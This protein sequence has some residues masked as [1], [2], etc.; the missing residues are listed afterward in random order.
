MDGKAK[1][2]EH[3]ASV[4]PRQSQRRRKLKRHRALQIERLESRCLLTA[5]LFALPR[6]DTGVIVELNPDNGA[7][8]R[9]F[10]APVPAGSATNGL[11]YDGQSLFY[12]SYNSNTLYQLDPDTG[13]V[14]DA[15]TFPEL[16]A[17]L[18]DGLAALN[19]L[20]YLQAAGT[21]QILIVD[22]RSD[23]IVGSHILGGLNLVGGFTAVDDPDELIALA[24][25]NTAVRIAP[26]TG[27]VLGTFSLGGF[28]ALGAAYVNGSLYFGGGGSNQIR[29]TNR[30]GG[31]LTTLTLPYTVSALAGDPHSDASWAVDW[32]VSIDDAT[33][34]LYVFD[35][36]TDTVW[37]TVNLPMS[38]WND[39]REVVIAADQSLAFVSDMQT[40]GVWVVDLMT[41]SLAAGVN[42]IP[43]SG[44]PQD[45]EITPDG[46]F[47]L[48]ADGSGGGPLSVVEIAARAEVGTYTGGNQR[49]AVAAAEGGNVLVA[50]AQAGVVRRLLL[51]PT[52]AVS[53]L[54]QTL[55]VPNVSNVV[56]APDGRTGVALNGPA[57]AIQSFRLYG[58][59]AVDLRQLPALPAE[60]PQAIG[61]VFSP[62]GNRFYARSDTGT[63]SVWGYDPATAQLSGSPL[64]IFSVGMADAAAGVDSLDITRDGAKLYISE[65]SVVTVYDAATGDPLP[66]PSAPPGERNYAG[67][68]LPAVPAAPPGPRGVYVDDATSSVQVFDLSSDRLIGSLP[69]PLPGGEATWEVALSPD[70][71]LAF[72]AH[73][74]A[75]LV[76]V[77][78]VAAV[79]LAAG[80]NPIA[81]TAYPGDLEV[82]PDGRYLLAAT[83]LGFGGPLSVVDV[84]L[85]SEISLSYVGASR[86]AVT[87]SQSGSVLVAD[88]G[89]RTVRRMVLDSNGMLIDTGESLYEPVSSYVRNVVLAP[90]GRTGV[91]VNSSE[92]SLRSFMVS[93]MRG[94]D[95][96]VLPGGGTA[97]GGV[98][99]PG[100]DRFFAR[101]SDG[102]LTAWAYDPATAAF[103]ESPLYTQAVGT[104]PA[105]VGSDQL[106]VS[107]DGN[108][109]YVTASTQVKV[110]DAATG[111]LLSSLADAAHT[112]V[113]IAL[114]GAQSPPAVPQG[115][116]LD[117]QNATL[118][119][120]NAD[121]RHPLGAVY[122][123]PSPYGTDLRDV[124]MTPDQ[125]WAFVA[126][127]M[128]RRVW[129]VDLSTRR[130]A[131]GVNPI[132][133]NAVPVDL[134][135]SANGRFLL[136]GSDPGYGIPAILAVDVATRAVRGTYTPEN[137]AQS[138][139]A[140]T[141]DGTVLSADY[142]AG[143]VRGVSLSVGGGLIDTGKT[144]AFPAV[145]NV[146]PA[147]DGRTAVA[148]G[149]GWLRS[150]VVREMAVVE[151]RN[152]G[153]LPQPE[154]PPLGGVFSPD[155]HRLYVR[156]AGTVSAWGYYPAT[157][158]L[159]GKP[160]YSINAGT[161][162]NLFG[163]DQIDI[164]AD[165]SRLYVVADGAVKVYDAVSGGFV[166]S[167][168]QGSQQHTGVSVAPALTAATVPVVRGVYLDRMTSTL[169]VLDVSRDQLL[170]TVT[171][172]PAGATATHEA[173]ISPDQRLAFVSDY[174][175]QAIWVVDLETM[176]LAAGTN[177]IPV[178]TSPEDMDITPDGRFLLVS[179][180]TAS[181][182]CVVDIAARQ[183]VS[184]L[185]TTSAESVAVGRDG[186]V[187]IGRAGTRRLLLTDD[188]VLVD[189]GQYLSGVG[190]NVVVAPDGR[191]GVQLGSTTVRSFW[192]D[193]MT[194]LDSRSLGSVMG[195]V[196]SPRGDRLFV[197]TLGSLSAWTYNPSTGKLGENPLYVVL[198]GTSDWWSGV[199]Q[200]DISPDGS[201][202]YVSDNAAL[203]IYDAA[204]GGLLRF[205]GQGGHDY[206]GVDLPAAELPSRVAPM[207]GVVI[208]D[209]TSTLHVIDAATDTVLGSL[210]L[211]IS[212]G[213]STWDVAITPDQALAFVADHQAKLVWGVDLNTISLLGSIV[214][215]PSP[216]DLE[217]TPDGRFL[218]VAD[219]VSAP[220]GVV[221]IA[222]WAQVSTGRNATSVTAAADGT[223][224][225][226][227]Y[228]GNRVDRL[229]LSEEGSLTATGESLA[230][231]QPL[232]VVLAPD[233]R[234]GVALTYGASGLQSFV[235]AGMAAVDLRAPVDQTDSSS[236]PVSAVFSPGGDRLYVRSSGGMVSAWAYDLAT[237]QLGSLPLY[238]VRAGSASVFLGIDQLDLSPDG[239]KLYVTDNTAVKVYDAA[240]GILLHTWGD[241]QHDY[242]GLDFAT[243][244]AG[245][246][247]R[248][249]AVDLE[250]AAVHIFNP[251]NNALLGIVPM[252]SPSWESARDVAISP[253]QRQAF[254]T[255]AAGRQVWVVDLD[256]LRLADRDNPLPVNLAPQDV[257][258]TP[259]GR[260]LLVAGQTQQSDEPL[261]SVI[262]LAT[263][264]VAGTYTGGPSFSSVAAGP[265]GAVLLADWQAGLVR[266]LTLLPSGA[267]TDPD[268][269]LMLAGA[270]NVVLAPDGR[271]GVALDL[272]GAGRLQS[273]MV[274]G[275]AAVDVRAASGGT[276]AVGGVFS[277][278]GYR[279]YAQTSDGRVSAWPY[280]PAT[281]Q[282][283]SAPLYEIS[284]NAGSSAVGTD[285]ID[286]SEDGNWL[287]VSDGTRIRSYDAATGVA[288]GIYG[289]PGRFA[290]L[291][292]GHVPAAPPVLPEVRGAYLDDNT[293]TLH[294][295]DV[296]TDTLV[297]TVPLPIP[298]GNRA[299]DVAI[300]PDQTL[301]F[302][303]DYESRLV[304]AVDLQG[305][306]IATGIN[307]I[308]VGI[309]IAD[310][311]VTPDGRHLLVSGSGYTKI[312]DVATRSPGT[313]LNVGGAAVA[314]GAGGDVLVA[315]SGQVRRLTIADGAL[316]NTGQ[317]LAAMSLFNVVAA[318]GGR[319][320]VALRYGAS[321][322]VQ[323]F[324][325]SPAGLAAVD[326]R[327]LAN[328]MSAVFSP[329]GD[330][331]YVRTSS[332]LSAWA[333]DPATGQLGNSPWFAV[334][335]VPAGPLAGVDQLDISPD[336]SRLYATSNTVVMVHD[337]RTGRM[338][339]AFANPAHRYYGLDV[340]SVAT[341][342][343][344]IAASPPHRGA[345]IDDATSMLHVIDVNTGSVL[346]RVVLP[347]GNYTLD[348]AITPD[349][350]W[351]F[352]SETALNRLW[353]VDLAT[354]SLADGVNPVPLTTSAFDLEVSP[355]SRF[356]LVSDGSSSTAPLN[357]VDV[358]TRAVVGSY[359]GGIY[360]NAVA[361]S[362]S[363][364][365]A[366]ADSGAGQVRRLTLSRGG[367]LTDTG[368][369]L[370]LA[371]AVNVVFA[372]DG[373]NGVAL[374]PSGGLQSFLVAG[375][376]PVANR[377]LSNAICGVFRPQGDRFYARTSNGSLTAWSYDAATGQLGELPLFQISLGNA[378]AP[379][380]VDQL[381]ISPDGGVLYVTDGSAI[382]TYDAL[383]GEFLG[384]QGRPGQAYVGLDIAADVPAAPATAAATMRGVYVD[385]LTG[386]VHVLDAATDTLLA[387]LPLPSGYANGRWD[388]A[389]APDQSRAF[390]ADQALGGIWVVDLVGLTLE[391]IPLPLQLPLHN[392][393]LTD[394][395]VTADGRFLLA[396]GGSKLSVVEIA[397]KSVTD[398][399]DLGTIS[400][401][402]IGS[403]GSVLVSLPGAG[404]VRR[405]VLDVGGRL[406]DLEQTLTVPAAHNVVVAPDGRTA[407]VFD[408]NS[409]TLSSFFVFGM[410]GIDTRQLS[411]T[412]PAVGGAFSPHG[413]R[414]FV[415]TGAGTVTAWS[416]DPATGRLGP[417]PLYTI[418]VGAAS[419]YP[420][421]DQLDVSPDGA[422]LY[423][424]D[425]TAVK[426]YDTA[427]GA[428]LHSLAN[429]AHRYV[430]IDLSRPVATAAPRVAVVDDERSELYLLD[431]S[432]LEILSR[433]PLGSLTGNRYTLDVVVSPDRSLA[434]VSE[435]NLSAVWVVDL[436][437]AELAAGTNPIPVST[438]P[439]DLELTPDGRFLLV[440][441]GPSAPLSVVDVAAR[442]QI[443]TYLP[444]TS[445]DAVAAGSGG[446][447]LVA[448]A[449]GGFVRRWAIDTAG[450]MSDTGHVLAHSGAVNVVLAPNGV[451]GVALS[452]GIIQSF[453]VPGMSPVAS[454]NAGNAISG[455]FSPRGDRFYVRTVDGLLSAWSHDPGTG[456]LGQFPLY[457]LSVGMTAAI[458]GVD[459]VDVSPDGTRLFVSGGS[460]V[461][462]Y[463]TATGAFIARIAGSGVNFLG[464]DVFPE[465]A[466]PPAVAPPLGMYID[467]NTSLL[468][469]FDVSQDVLLGKVPIPNNSG[470]G[471]WDVAMTPDGSLA[472]VSDYEGQS[473]WVV[474]LQTISLATWGNPISLATAAQDLDVTPDGRY[475]LVSG[476][477]GSS[478]ISVVDIAAR[479][480]VGSS[481]SGSWNAVA[482]GYDG[483]LL[484][485]DNALGHVRRLLIANGGPA[486]DTGQSLAV[487]AVSNVILAPDGRT[488][489]GLGL[490]SH[491]LQSFQAGSMTAVDTRTQ[492]WPISAVFSPS[493]DRLYVRSGNGSIGVWAYDPATGQLGSDP[494]FS[495]GVAS[496]PAYSGV[497]QLAISPDGTKLYVTESPSVRVYDATNGALLTS[498]SDIEHRYVGIVAGAGLAPPTA[499]RQRGV[500]IDDQTGTLHVFDPEAGVWLGSVP[501]PG[502]SGNRTWDAAVSPDQTVAFVTDSEG[503]R[504]WVVDL[505]TLRLAEGL[506][507]LALGL[508]PEDLD[509]TRDGRFLL[510]GGQPWQ[511]GG[512]NLA[513]VD[514]LTR[515]P[516][517]MIEI[518]SNM[519]TV[520]AGR[521][522]QVLIAEPEIGRVR[523]LSLSAEGVLADT[524][525][526]LAMPGPAN[527]IV[528]PDGRTG[529]AVSPSAGV[530]QSFVVSGL[531]AVATRSLPEVLSGAF[532]PSGYRFY[533]RT[534]GSISGWGYDP[535]TGQLS[536][537]PLFSVS[538]GGVPWTAGADRIDVSPDGNLLYA[539]SAGEVRIY[540]ATTGAEV[541]SPLVSDGDFVGLDIAP[542]AVATQRPVSLGAYV[543]ANSSLLYVFDAQTDRVLGKLLLPSHSGT[544]R[545]VVIAPD[546]TRAFVLDNGPKLVWTVDLTTISLA[547]GG[548]P[549]S[550]SE[551]PQDA[552]VTADGRWLLIGNA[553]GSVSVVNTA[554]SSLAGPNFS[555]GGQAVAVGS[556]EDLVV[557]NYTAG[558]VRRLAVSRGGAIRDTGQK[559]LLPT[560]G[561]VTLAP[562]GRTGVAIDRSGRVAQPFLLSGMQSVA[563]RVLPG[564]G[565]AMGGVFNP[566]G[567]RFYVRTSDGTLSAWTYDP[568][569]AELGAEPL[570]VRWAGT[571]SAHVGIDQMALSPDGSR[572]LVTD[573]SVVR[574]YDPDTGELLGAWGRY[575]D[576]YVGIDIPAAQPA[577]PEPPLPNRGAYIDNNT[578]TLQVLDLATDT[579]LGSVVL[580][581]AG[582]NQ[583]WD[584]VMAPGQGL[585][586]V[587]DLES[588]RIWVVDLDSLAL[589]PG[590]NPIL[591]SIEPA[592]MDVTPD[593]RFLLAGGVT[594]TPITV[595]DLATRAE[596]GDGPSAYSGAAVAAGPHGTVLVAQ[597]ESGSGRVSRYAVGADG[598]LHDTGQGLELASV[599]NVVLAPDGRT[600]VAIA[601]G[602]D[603]F[604]SFSVVGMK[605][606]A[607]R[608][609]PAGSAPS[610]AVF[611]PRGDRLFVRTAA[612]TVTAWSYD[613]ATGQVGSAPLYTIATGMAGYQTGADDL[614]VSPDGTRLYVTGQQA[615]NVYEAATGG[616]LTTLAD[617]S[618]AYVGIV[619]PPLSAAR[620]PVWG[621]YVEANASSLQIVDTNTDTWFG[622]VAL[623]APNTTLRD[624]VIAPDQSLAF[625]SEPANSRVWVVDL[626]TLSLAAGRNPIPLGIPAQDL[627][628][629]PDG[630]YL[631]AGNGGGSAPLVVVDMAA[632]IVVSRY[633]DAGYR[634]AV[635]T[636][637]AGDVLVADGTGTA[638]RRLTLGYGGV[639][640]GTGESLALPNVDNLVAA[641]DGRT[642][643]ALQDTG[644][645][646]SFV[647]AGMTAVDTRSRG[648]LVGGIFSPGGDRL[649]LR[650]SDGTVSAWGYDPAT[651]QVDETPLF[652]VAAGGAA[653]YAGVDGI[654]ISPDGTRLYVTASSTT[655][656]L[657][658]AQGALLAFFTDP[659]HRYVGL[660]IATPPPPAAPGKIRGAV[661]EDRNGNGI[662]DAGEPGVPGWQIYLDRYQRGVANIGGSL[663]PDDYAVGTTL[664]QIPL[665]ATLSA[666]GA[667]V[668]DPTVTAQRDLAAATGTMV[669]ANGDQRL[670]SAGSRAL[671]VDFAQNVRSIRIDFSSQSALAQGQLLVYDAAGNLVDGYTT[672]ML[673]S[674]Q[675]ETMAV[676]SPSTAIA[677]AV[678]SGLS[679][680]PGLLD[681]L[682]VGPAERSALTD[683]D[684][685]Y[686]FH[687]VEAGSYV[688]AEVPRTGWVPTAPSPAEAAEVLSW[689]DEAAFLAAHPAAVL[690]TFDGFSQGQLLGGPS[691]RVGGVNY[692]SNSSLV[693]WS[694]GPSG[695]GTAVSGPNKLIQ[696]LV[697]PPPGIAL[698][699]WILTFGEG[700]LVE[701]IGFHVL[702]A[703]LNA[704]YQILVEDAA[705]AVQ[706][707]E[708][709][710]PDDPTYRGF[711]SAAGIRQITIRHDPAASGA[712]AFALDNVA[713]TPLQ[714]LLPGMHLVDL[715]P[716]QT[717]AGLDFGNRSDVPGPPDL[718]DSVPNQAGRK[719]Q[720]VSLPE[721]TFTDPGLTFDEYTATVNWGDG[722][723]DQPAVITKPTLNAPGAVSGTHI[724]EQ[725]GVYT[726][727]VTVRD[728]DLGED[729]ISFTM[730]IGAGELVDRWIFYN[731]SAYD[732][733]D[734]AANTGDFS[735]IAPHTPVVGG[736]GPHPT[737]RDEPG[738]E[739]GKEALL[740]GQTATYANYTSY[741]RGINGIMVDLVGLF[742]TPTTADFEFRVGNHD[743][744]AS[745]AVAPTPASITVFPGAG[746]PNGSGAPSDRV[747]IIW[748]D[749][750][751]QNTWLQ[752][753]VLA[754]AVTGLDSPDVFYFGNAI[755]D[756]G[757]ANTSTFAF[758][759]VTDELA[760]RG[761]PH[762]F[763]NPAPITDPH[764]F[765]KDSFVTVSDELVARNHGTNFLNALRLITVPALPAGGMPLGAAA[766]AEFE[767]SQSGL[768]G[769]SADGALLA[770]ADPHSLLAMPVAGRFDAQLVAR[771]FPHAAS[772]SPSPRPRADRLRDAAW[773]TDRDRVFDVVGRH[774]PVR[775]WQTVESTP[776]LDEVLSLLAD[777]AQAETAPSLDAVFAGW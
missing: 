28:S 680:Y 447:V 650:S 546:Q 174:D 110:Y 372:P 296:Q 514:L 628:I 218:L 727:T 704:Q 270:A 290:G 160:L 770:M 302:V 479:R 312:I 294:V 475:L 762:N 121:T 359:G 642:G 543:A 167:F 635:T 508:I 60:F 205:L 438:S 724:Y 96:R 548:T 320:G 703:V 53:D 686:V 654:D 657:D 598:K 555:A 178:G 203:R 358:R 604:H 162:G 572:L 252:P 613:P 399:L 94:S 61:G 55:S 155:G 492:A 716:G 458:P 662:R 136:V 763:Q 552:A 149:D 498:F 258:V 150:F 63:L 82:T 609:L 746:T 468:H 554:T 672:A 381:D 305:L 237:G 5:R 732:G 450:T 740:P 505:Q 106:A 765:N 559:F 352:V 738:K 708:H 379:W 577:T 663:E 102:T 216:A 288:H 157:G 208:D 4:S 75:R 502:A 154:P 702:P 720:V 378:P 127:S 667:D 486:V 671:R 659:A 112:Y 21:E 685:N 275:L 773:T 495:F 690:E 456:Q 292:L 408:T 733:N 348:V 646:T 343:T 551:N 235:V 640:T 616:L 111:G 15:D 18:V 220:I 9:R 535:H 767:G 515:T 493:G 775:M 103:G 420:G 153:Q 256:T 400:G 76:W 210:A 540:D 418:A 588:R 595:V 73:T 202:L 263:G 760:A 130:L 563:A 336:G 699:Q 464:L 573:N 58:M 534:A 744:P 688:V 480:L 741:S 211:P 670:W 335:S 281:G 632:R 138:T 313:L 614:A 145:M 24:D 327:P 92:N 517:G 81:V 169:H 143:V 276:S 466:E 86:T 307:P 295:F 339:R 503:R 182:V 253:D 244:A 228:E 46:R 585:A 40:R 638:V 761:H 579:L 26:A 692:A 29:V 611:N 694:A 326:F 19:G 331:L 423:V 441:D 666:V 410:M 104:A 570:F 706:V 618:H 176:D 54:G 735:A 57:A 41:R 78:D 196:F 446:T 346:G 478:R 219:D 351:A 428:W 354:I 465:P 151:G 51:S 617:A 520:S 427:S 470:N 225:A 416:Y 397:T 612:R 132:S 350:A 340:P 245:A 259:D 516:V 72:V 163:V 330:M 273:F 457:E 693:L 678:I 13:A 187:L 556:G 748:S 240:D 385:D 229:V 553:N 509:I 214:V 677:A 115:V 512:P 571:A 191:T 139:V 649:Y 173:V 776:G 201:K 729:A 243:P 629:T 204:T 734:P 152:F 581:G 221:S 529:V 405:L 375:M 713:H 541:S 39:T 510:V 737:G 189:T 665:I 337:A 639:L 172:P 485:G 264:R 356:L 185:A 725:D 691:I 255:D 23:T 181:P 328:A 539:T 7:E 357:V 656:V 171:L 501:L 353:V 747:T 80:T 648:G 117:R 97:I 569:T 754:T 395:E 592:D 11:A 318:P 526:T 105:I 282:F 286:I 620:P 374:S 68:D 739:L 636:T 430:G 261:L 42:P 745:W 47:L 301:A 712:I 482:A 393:N 134:D 676:V 297:G 453:L 413:D 254:V 622:A 147:P 304:W 267:V 388:V 3:A 684:G 285:Q 338:L 83:A 467:D 476:G 274:S 129:V 248:G 137:A 142:Q 434:F 610:S 681:H 487:P 148:M 440:G 406:T 463:S 496:V 79:A 714:S 32:G 519:A 49:N 769:G 85:R 623:P 402:S 84:A 128:G 213:N 70:Q 298:P 266:R 532:S 184:T 439:Q 62:A 484:V 280:N 333:Y 578:G 499:Q 349:Q 419:V 262:E 382:K 599:R 161:A 459:L 384:V 118:H 721:I 523:H 365:V 695:P 317:T 494:L 209:A 544:V 66:T 491:L 293:S 504:V 768:D 125:A 177:P 634:T 531:T 90:D 50:D 215:T 386:T 124:V 332:T 527:V 231:T 749:N 341:T 230:V 490:S 557:A 265:D 345:Y 404:L 319:T 67:V 392:G 217:V 186:N 370:E 278:S 362:A 168:A 233:G 443:G 165:S 183:Q 568:A 545:D 764:D 750:A 344:E 730:F 14:L 547:G 321:G 164:S 412:S 664:D 728:D 360:R 329:D 723:G 1:R 89:G 471:T 674:G 564:G 324:G 433:I 549:L 6:T 574:G 250:N 710:F 752:I 607:S 260:F 383:T 69:L 126:D 310:L 587:A 179:N 675:R 576:V 717:Q 123:P 647:V 284:V 48:V 101:S 222:A 246:V 715:S 65:K 417:M 615:V 100:G 347:T 627:D 673:S 289:G 566:G 180:R 144:L 114:P 206:A 605:P 316:F 533:A 660:D 366:V 536:G 224:V 489:V 376:T 8:L 435:S 291:D 133:L 108:R 477:D 309:S 661:W 422:R 753:T 591:V 442:A 241:A 626:V 325:I 452:N 431:G 227:D 689:N 472:F 497:D 107:P 437:T 30:A 45:L 619:M 192:V 658:A 411:G 300:T 170:G 711:R 586:Y 33:S 633:S 537:A 140:V 369:S 772:D 364:D 401:I 277:P 271:T 197:R 625:V 530:I 25:T 199:D 146:V 603:S 407:V 757:S 99:S 361:V 743:D 580:P 195:G 488:G 44:Y 120:F 565:Y 558:E 56:M 323:S 421:A 700:A 528:A 445:R 389:I 373:H 131:A 122:L 198:T 64:Q 10:P 705:G 500:T 606:V 226:A 643:V 698:P 322:G 17:A 371:G 88:Y 522:G 701:A 469:V 560:A 377:A 424:T 511:Y 736:H 777:P 98:F 637:R 43:I 461:S 236:R 212:S 448:D 562:D 223:V 707:F 91:M 22:P 460:G 631:L 608:F 521:I 159:S 436:N 71:S 27:E 742:G 279:F 601:T 409:R 34:T 38:T 403:R 774:K 398:S 311:E 597:P 363:G 303:A 481:A 645:F 584:V 473:V 583:T 683:E 483:E 415:R 35:T 644:S 239:A 668:T 718:V 600:A 722:T 771:G 234:T 589:A 462:V 391:P 52:G 696:G 283:G 158:Q 247:P 109:L 113:G 630:R 380:G 652:I 641:P 257:D 755:G 602:S 119:I 518:G 368:E 669:F 16:G 306:R 575:A 651:G 141:R 232:N 287:Y 193:G 426:V 251:R 175:L 455:A 135:V 95:R 390:V 726:V 582:G 624:T 429:V 207:R 758:V 200:L 561:D 342:G 166:A 425:N 308:D 194:E 74:Q 524:G 451:T 697:S 719:G 242:V 367:T 709:V 756:S 37:A 550:L 655:L 299:Q 20:I 387:Q 682:V 596:V 355:D 93:G 188:G 766:G 759:T 396:A 36:N 679:G 731:N 538:A 507:P 590:I 687:D 156:T 31:L 414:F 506:N 751:I 12:R 314:A 449:S 268:Q 87:V 513:V 542:L 2:P 454:R 334:P 621:V 190:I 593:G 77:V 474:D 59:N 567:D 394:L 269:T 315:E 444:G 116:Y 653:A 249:V 238:S 432:R 272:W 525:Q 594:N